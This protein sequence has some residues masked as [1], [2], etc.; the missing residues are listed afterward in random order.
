[1]N[2]E[3]DQDGAQS[4]PDT[5]ELDAIR[6]ELEDARSALAAARTA[7]AEATSAY[8]AEARAA[9]PTIPPSLIDGDSPAAIAASVERATA[10]LAEYDAL[11]PAASANGHAVT[12][13]IPRGAMAPVALPANAT[14]MDKIRAGLVAR[15]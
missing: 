5:G 4:P 10:T 7:Q 9:R 15:S 1:M 14:A 13:P 2:E 11:R 8:L 3:E 6:A 12:V